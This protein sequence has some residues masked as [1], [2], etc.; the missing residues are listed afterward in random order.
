MCDATQHVCICMLT[1]DL[2][3]EIFNKRRLRQ[4]ILPLAS[5]REFVLLYKGVYP[6]DSVPPCSKSNTN[7]EVNQKSTKKTQ[8]TESRRCKSKTEGNIVSLASPDNSVNVSASCE[9]R[10]ASISSHRPITTSPPN[11]SPPS[12]QTVR[13]KTR[14]PRVELKPSKCTLHHGLKAVDEAER[15]NTQ[16]K[17]RLIMSLSSLAVSEGISVC[18]SLETTTLVPPQ[19][20]PP[21]CGN[22]QR[23]EESGEEELREDTKGLAHDTIEEL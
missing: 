22:N 17:T 23:G 3:L 6:P 16:Q 9:G 5:Q 2:T 11:Q 19:A 15:S 10:G 20:G 4:R 7:N 18:G 14:R 13:N 12:V 1:L 21:V 8:K